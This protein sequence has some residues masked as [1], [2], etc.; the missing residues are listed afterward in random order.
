MNMQVLKIE[1]NRLKNTEYLSFMSNFKTYMEQAGASELGI[2]LLIGIFLNY[3][4]R[5]HAAL[6]AER[7]DPIV[8]LLSKLDLLRDNIYRMFY[9]YIKAFTFSDENQQ[10]EAADEVMR[11]VKDDENP[12]T[13]APDRE[14][15]LL[16]NIVSKLRTEPFAGYI[17]DLN[18]DLLLDKIAVRNAEYKAKSI[19][20]TKRKSDKESISIREIRKEM[21]P[22]YRKMISVINTFAPHNADSEAFQK[23][24]KLMN[25]EISTWNAV[26]ARRKSKKD[27]NNNNDE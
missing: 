25:A 5:A 1:L 21:D 19:E 14:S 11:I 15:I 6:E 22:S 10:K 24:I 26:I 9:Y 3:F 16:D 20:R 23:F 17:S 8:Q 27:S 18:A 12:L 7:T 4:S 2:Q 13:V